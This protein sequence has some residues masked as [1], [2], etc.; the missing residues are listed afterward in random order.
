MTTTASPSYSIRINIDL[1]PILNQPSSVSPPVSDTPHLGTSV[2]ADQ[3]T[4]LPLFVASSP[5]EKSISQP[6]ASSTNLTRTP[7]SAPCFTDVQC[8]FIC[9]ISEKSL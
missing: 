2:P 8:W 6:T 1:P 9:R 7:P 5:A 4:D 3:P